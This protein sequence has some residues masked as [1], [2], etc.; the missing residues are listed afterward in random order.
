M[1]EELHSS[2]TSVLTRATRHNIPEHSILHSHCPENLKSYTIDIFTAIE[3]SGLMKFKE[4]YESSG[5]NI[6][7]FASLKNYVVRDFGVT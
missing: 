6:V 4:Y 3:T 1:T 5:I 7:Y 2:E